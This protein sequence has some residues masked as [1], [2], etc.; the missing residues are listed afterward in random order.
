SYNGD[1]PF[2]HLNLLVKK[3]LLVKK[4]I[5]E[6]EKDIKGMVLMF[7]DTWFLIDNIEWENDNETRFGMT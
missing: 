2:Y 4:E 7:V 3:K 5:T 1:V 6:D